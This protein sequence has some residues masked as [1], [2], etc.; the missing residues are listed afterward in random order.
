MLYRPEKTIPHAEMLDLFSDTR[1]VPN[2]AISKEVNFRLFEGASCG[3]LVLSQNVGEDQNVCFEPGREVIIYEHGVEL[4]D[5]AACY[6][7]NSR[8]AEKIAR[9]AWL[10]VHAEHLPEHR[11]SELLALARNLDASAGGGR[12]KGSAADKYFYLTLQQLDFH[13]SHKLAPLWLFKRLIE[14][15]EDGEVAAAVLQTLMKLDSS[16]IKQG[17]DYCRQILHS[18]AHTASTSCNLAASVFC[19]LQGDA[20]ASILFLQRQ[21]LTMQGENNPGACAPA[22]SVDVGEH[23][24]L[25]DFYMLWARLLYRQKILARPGCHFEPRAGILPENA[26]ECL[27][28][29]QQELAEIRPDSAVSVKKTEL[30]EQLACVFSA[31]HGYDYMHMGSL[32]YL[33]LYDQNNWRKQLA[34]GLGELQ[35]L[36]VESGLDELAEAADKAA[37]Q[38]ETKDFLSLLA[39]VPSYDRIMQV[40]GK[41]IML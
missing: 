13:G 23:T 24:P 33:A 4:L 27:L 29:A 31:V 18:S 1:L 20:P 15:P 6:K 3:C 30:M 12:A 5:K 40:L 17:L 9:A 38:G 41:C 25:Y 14:L 35:C 11:V 2:E 10:R 7:K 28:L 36:K 39:A 21:I 34:Y 22:D 16:Y 32:A 19:R 26:L 8:A 37:K